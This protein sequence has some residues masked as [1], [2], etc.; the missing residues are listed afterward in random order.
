MAY[1]YAQHLSCLWLLHGCAV[2]V[3][4]VTDLSQA[5]AHAPLY[6]RSKAAK[7]YNSH[8]SRSGGVCTSDVKYKAQATGL[9]TE[10]QST[11]G[12]DHR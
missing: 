8:V 9:R 6:A 1:R 7:R 12:G 4:W 3:R 10:S 2:Q 11:K 5:Q